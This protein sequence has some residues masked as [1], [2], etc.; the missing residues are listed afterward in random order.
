MPK[1]KPKPNT[2]HRSGV[3]DKVVGAPA[4]LPP[5]DLPLLSD[6]LAKAKLI[7]TSL[8]AEGSGKDVPNKFVIDQL[9]IDITAMY[10]RANSNLV[11]RIERKVKEDLEKFYGEYRQLVR[12]G[13]SSS[14]PKMIAFQNKCEKLFD[15]IWCKCKILP[16]AEV[17]CEGCIPA[18]HITCNCSKEK[19]IPKM[20]LAYVMDQRDRQG[21]KGAMQMAGFDKKGTTKM[22]ETLDR[23]EKDK[24]S[25]TPKLGPKKVKDSE[26]NRKE[27]DLQDLSTEHLEAE[28]D[29]FVFDQAGDDTEDEFAED[30]EDCDPDDSEFVPDFVN[31]EGIA[32]KSSKTR[33]KMTLTNIVRECMRWGVSPKAGASI[34]NAAFIDAGVVNKEN[35]NNIIDKNKLKRQMEKYQNDIREKEMKELQLDP[36][37]GI[38]LDGKKDDTLTLEQDERGVWKVVQYNEEHYTLGIEPGGQYLGHVAPE[39][40]KAVKIVDSIMK[41]VREN[42]IDGGWKVVGSDSTSCITGNIGGVICLLEKALGRKLFWSICLLHT[43]ELPL[44]N[45]FT[46]LDGPTSGSNSFKGVIGKLLPEVADMEWNSKFKPISAGP[47][48]EELSEEVFRELSTDQKYL[49]L[50]ILAV[51]SGEIPDKLKSLKNGPISHSRWLTLASALLVMYM[52]KNTLKGKEKKNLETLVHFIV[53]N[54]GPMW[55]SIKSKPSIIYGPRHYFKQIQLIRALPKKVQEVVKENISRSAYHA[56]PENILL[57]MLGDESQEVRAKAVD[58]ITK[59]REGSNDPDKGD[60]SVRKFIVPELNYNCK[61]YY[62]MIDFEEETVYEPNLTA[63]LT[64]GDL[65]KIKV[66]KLVVKKFSNNN[67]SVE[68]L[69]KETSRACG[70]VVGWARRDGYMRS[71]AKSRSLMP[72]FESKQDYQ[73]NFE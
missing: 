7:K 20:E 31:V 21:G 3:A 68:K 36:P 27:N 60:T 6:V 49:R 22:Q 9:Y 54:Y 65:D 19:K 72:K 67:Q 66:E 25:N 11:L 45:I 61:R 32:N 43:N 46:T 14:S 18:A 23:K 47:G 28:S 40:G 1:S 57:S 62:E 50:A 38:Y 16:C 44:R 10:R 5:G 33:N 42:A 70:K 39:G 2:R 41:F 69:V 55:F 35:Q 8:T 53:T 15:M 26:N 73:N 29:Q 37:E 4:D 48:L 12:S 52:K 17:A 63:D 34:A 58:L 56:H 30:S 64:L 71:S 59:L 51:M 24:Q 13:A